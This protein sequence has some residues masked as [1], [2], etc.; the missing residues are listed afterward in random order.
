MAAMP[1]GFM[2]AMT[3]KFRRWTTRKASQLYSMKTIIQS[4]KD[5]GGWNTILT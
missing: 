5:V 1:A 4:A 2:E 3:P